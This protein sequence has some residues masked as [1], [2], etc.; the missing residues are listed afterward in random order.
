MANSV[1]AGTVWVNCYDVFDAAAPF[2]GFKMSASAANW[3]RI[4]DKVFLIRH[5]CHFPHGFM[6]I[7]ICDIEQFC[8]WSGIVSPHVRSPIQFGR[9]PNRTIDLTRFPLLFDE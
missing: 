7:Y 9:K 3:A 1:R 2:G 4:D 8:E 5:A 6:L